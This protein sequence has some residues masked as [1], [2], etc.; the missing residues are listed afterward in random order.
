MVFRKFLS[1]RSLKQKV[2]FSIIIVIVAGT[3]VSSYLAAKDLRDLV[4]IEIRD[5]ARSI[6]VMGEA[7]REYTADNW[8]RQVFQK[9][10]LMQDPEG[11]FL[12]SV[13]IFSSIKTMNKKAEELNYRFRVPKVNPRNKD[14]TPTEEEALILEK[15]KRE[16]LTEYATG[17]LDSK[18][19]RYYRSI[20][21]TEDCLICHGDPSLSSE[22]WGNTEGID[23][24]GAKM[25]NWKAG[26]IHG[27]FMLEY[28]LT[29]FIASQRLAIMKNLIVGVAILLLSIIAIIVV[30]KRAFDPLDK[31]SK[32][33]EEINQGAGDLTKKI[34]VL[35]NDEIGKVAVLFNQF[36]DQLRDMILN[37]SDA[38]NHVSSSSEE[39]T[40]A[41]QSLANIAQDQAASIE[42]TSSAMEEIKA[43]IDSVS[44]NAKNQAD[45]AG[46]T[47]ESMMYLADSIEK[48]DSSAQS[49][50]SMAEATSEYA[51]EG[52]SILIST[53]DGMKEIAKSS[54][55]I[56]DIVSIISD[57]TDQIN[58][59]SLN[60]SIEAAR[61]GDQGKGFAVVAEEIAKLADQTAKS[62]KQIN[63]LIL[64]TN[65]KV[66]SGAALV[67]RTAESLRK[68][69]ENVKQSAEIMEGIAS[70]AVQLNSK[71]EQVSQEVVEVNRMSEEIS[72]MMEEQSIS[73]NEIISAIDQ[74]ND[75][76][77]QVSSGSEE[78]AAGSEELASQAEGLNSIVNRFKLD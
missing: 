68:I 10:Y 69:L 40:A 44:G 71:S 75:I 1:N 45:K 24:T 51:I 14:N 41:S 28:D 47:H 7:V 57:I 58:L 65:H 15:L 27:A 70:S 67:E 30:V 56:T 35:R 39:M 4:F 12:Y 61:A 22:L 78:L 76:T 11:K 6:T 17:D 62:S 77:Q 42:Q 72:I 46:T 8:D 31:I 52:E 73:S 38:A 60:A 23:P 37:V 66:D 54:N 36:I 33:L 16:D 26:E 5:K 64:Q 49:A 43:T 13:P 3:A 2:V 34:P 32:S 63:D 19:I 18:K 21:L 59:L 50:N 74:I 29:E 20:R 48:I 53:V 9:E 55:Q 25:E